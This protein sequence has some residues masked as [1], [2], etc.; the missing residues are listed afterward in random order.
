MKI[1]FCAMRYDYG[2]TKRGLSYEYYNYLPTFQ[3]L[4]NQVIPFDYLTLYKKLG[5]DKMNDLLWKTVKNLKTHFF[6]FSLFQ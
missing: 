2:N 1:L 4:G 6:F 3:K 5:R